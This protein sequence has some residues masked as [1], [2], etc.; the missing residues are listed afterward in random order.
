M[1][2]NFLILFSSLFIM[3]IPF[4]Y[5]YFKSKKQ[6]VSA[7]DW[8]VGGRDL[9]TYVIVGTQFASAMGGGVLVALV[10]R[11]YSLGLSTVT[12]GLA[13]SIPFFV[14][15]LLAPWIRSQ[16]FTTI[17]DIL[18][19]FYGKNKALSVLG[20]FFAL[21][22]PF[23]WITSQLGAFGILYSG[24]TGISAPILVV[25]ISVISLFF[26]MP[27]GLK[28]VAWTDFIFACFMIVVCGLC[29]VFASKMGG[30]TSAIFNSPNVPVE[31]IS[32]PGGFVSVGWVTVAL[33]FTSALPGGCTNQI[34]YQRICSI[35]DPK[36]VN[37]SL[38]LSGISLILAIVWAYFMGTAVRALNPNLPNGEGATAWFMTQLPT[39]MLVM[40][41]GLVCAVIMSTISSAAQT[42]VTN[43]TT[44]IYKKSINPGVSDEQMI[45]MSRILTVIL[46]AVTCTLSLVFPDVLG[47]LVYTY[48]FSAA[49]LFGPIFIGFF[50]KKTKPFTATTV[51][52]SMVIAMIVCV[53]AK[54]T[55]SFGTPL[56][57]TIFGL[58]ASVATMLIAMPFQ[59]KNE[60]EK[61]A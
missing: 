7:E 30:G 41:A 58:G 29:V 1:S 3:L 11:G 6:E 49:G 5:S 50:T 28:T 40:F 8:A 2:N 36:K 35:K 14:L 19:D 39:W 44:D 25:G 23:G 43:L 21:I 32:F 53:I 38:F 46:M 10:G 26:I 22:V 34:Y 24:M 56:P 37:L 15:M 12:Y 59:K 31:N 4:L 16:N 60:I 20:A 45:R 42:T 57:F 27:S 55:G 61:A 13:A 47:W 52:A 54:A 33:W 17:P 48:A 51:L 9:P 18:E